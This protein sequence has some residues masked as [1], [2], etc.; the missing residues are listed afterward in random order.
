MI[1]GKAGTGIKKNENRKFLGDLRQKTG[2]KDQNFL[3][4]SLIS[5]KVVV[6]SLELFYAANINQIMI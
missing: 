1:K 6:L 4:Q 3:F 5:E 2:K